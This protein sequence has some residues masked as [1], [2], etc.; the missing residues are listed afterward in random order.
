MV[1]TADS[2]CGN[3]KAVL[4]LIQMAQPSTQERCLPK[5]VTDSTWTKANSVGNPSPRPA[6]R[7]FFCPHPALMLKIKL[8]I[9]T[10]ALDVDGI[11]PCYKTEQGA[12]FMGSL[13]WSVF[14]P[15]S[16]SFSFSSGN[17]PSQRCG[18]AFFVDTI[19]TY[20]I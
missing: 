6:R 13:L 3:C 12:P 20:S 9:D 4:S 5:S 8:Q 17:A 16:D 11:D 7:A 18:G 2:A 10:S 15:C 1:V 19:S 14:V